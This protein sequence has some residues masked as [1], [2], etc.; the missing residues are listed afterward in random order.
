LLLAPG[1]AR[2]FFGFG[3]F[4]LRRRALLGCRS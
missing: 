3:R 1:P 2:A 4:R